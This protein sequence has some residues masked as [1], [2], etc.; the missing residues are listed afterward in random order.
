LSTKYDLK[1]KDLG[2]EKNNAGHQIKNSHRQHFGL[3]LHG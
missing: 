2:V 3:T 1:T